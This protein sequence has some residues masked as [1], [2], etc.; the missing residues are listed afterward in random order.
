GAC[1]KYY[2]ASAGAIYVGDPVALGTTGDTEGV[3]GVVIATAGAT[4]PIL[5]V[6]VGVV[7]DPDNL[8]RTYLPASTAG[9]LLVADD[10]DILYEVQEDSLVSTLAATDIGGTANLIAGSGNTLTGLSGWEL[11]SSEADADATDQLLILGLAQRPDNVIGDHA[12]WLVKI[13]LPQAGKASA[14]A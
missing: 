14:G 11:D 4:N 3:P 12:K 5:G 9:Y 2:F 7:P 1:N 8:S 6:V 10:P 13:D